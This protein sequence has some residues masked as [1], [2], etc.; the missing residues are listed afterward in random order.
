MLPSTH[1]YVLSLSAENTD[2]YEAFRD[3][4]I[5]VE[6]QGFPVT[7]TIS[8]SATPEHDSLRVL[9]RSVDK[10]FD[11]YDSRE[12]LGLVVVGDEELQSAF[13]SITTHGSAVVGRVRGDRAGISANALGQIVWPVIKELMSAVQDRAIRELDDCAREGCVASGL[14]AV[15]AAT[16]AGDPGTLLVEDD[17]HVRGSLAAGTQAPVL[18]ENVDVRDVN[19]DAVDAVIERVLGSGGNVMFMQSGTLAGQGRIV[20][21]LRKGQEP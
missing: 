1:Y 3:A 13:D 6:N 14:N 19:D 20:L 15:V 21:L 8:A 4:L 16:N 9:M 17:Y 2:L 12:R 7:P 5:V 18:S 10:C 11:S